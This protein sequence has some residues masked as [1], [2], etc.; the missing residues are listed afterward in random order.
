MSMLLSRRSNVWLS[1]HSG[2]G[3]SQLRAES[4]SDKLSNT[5]K[6]KL[7]RSPLAVG[8]WKHGQESL[9]GLPCHWRE[10]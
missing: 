4:V 6:M 8:W 1:Q 7:V 2:H 10:A 5:F 3:S 9:H